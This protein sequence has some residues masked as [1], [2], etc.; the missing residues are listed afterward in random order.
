MVDGKVVRR[1]AASAD[2]GQ[3]EVPPEIEKI[4]STWASE[5]KTVCLPLPKDD[6]LVLFAMEDE[7]RPESREAVSDLHR[8]AIRVA[9]ITGDSKR[10]PIR[11]PGASG[12]MT[13][14]LRYSPVT[15]LRP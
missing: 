12:S 5:G 9:M 4:E 7:I 13:S 3:M 15:K 11:S 8:L 1:R 10:W 14:P 2:R 6:C